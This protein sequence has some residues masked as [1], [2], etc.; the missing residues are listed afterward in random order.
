MSLS[1]S[2]DANRW[3]LSRR[4][5]IRL[6]AGVVPAVWL[7]SQ[8]SVF[9]QEPE[10]QNQGDAMLS[11]LFQ[12]EES[13]AP[14]LMARPGMLA[15][16]DQRLKKRIGGVDAAYVGLKESWSERADALASRYAAPEPDFSFAARSD[17]LDLVIGL[18]LLEGQG[19]ATD[20]QRQAM[21]RTSLAL[22]DGLGRAGKKTIDLHVGQAS[23]MMPLAVAYDWLY[24]HLSADQRRSMMTAMIDYSVRP[25]L[26]A[27]Y[28]YDPRAWWVNGMNNW[29]TICIGGAIAAVLAARPD[30]VP[31]TFGVQTTANGP[32]VVR[33][34]AEHADDLIRRGLSNLRRPLIQLQSNNG[35]WGEGSGYQ[36]DA[37]LP[38]FSL[39]ASVEG[40]LKPGARPAGIVKAFLDD[41]RQGATLHL[42]SS[43]HLASP[44]GVDFPYSDG[45]WPLTK[46]PINLLVAGYGRDAA[47]PLWKA[48]AQQA[49]RLGGDRDRGLYLLYASQFDE[50]E[51]SP[52]ASE[53]PPT[54]IYFFSGK[55]ELP[56]E[57]KPVPNPH[58]VIW[59]QNWHDPL[60]AAVMFKGGDNRMD[61]H[62]HLDAG[63][64]IYDWAGVRWAIDLGRA[65]GYVPYLKDG[66][67]AYRPNATVFFQPYPKR[68]CGHNTLVINPADNDYTRR[69]VPPPWDWLWQINP[70][71][72]LFDADAWSPVTGLQTDAAADTWRGSVELTPVYRRHGA[73]E[74]CRRS[75]EF[76]CTSGR[77]TITDTLNFTGPN[78]DCWWFMHL[79]ANVVVDATNPRDVLL[80]AKLADGKTARLRVKVAGEHSFVFSPIDQNLPPGQP[81]DAWLWG[82]GQAIKQKRELKK[83]SIHCPT[84]TASLW[85]AVTIVPDVIS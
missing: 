78:N 47:S 30:D 48:V 55:A 66:N 41:A 80:S 2:D 15:R 83:L 42:Q 13:Q 77:L 16:A 79:P 74:G 54:G 9:G 8:A 33:P 4:Q 69:R 73:R 6:A 71:Q 25:T 62:S 1:H 38:W 12:F 70:D 31:G 7:Q 57:N 60:A 10:S 56:P 40:A 28:G 20:A 19:D 64:F 32:A 46:E 11:E 58:V 29:T 67:K 61:Y 14:R 22:V 76:D 68:A 53:A 84:S 36:H 27:L 5:I 50:A 3:T 23:N 44:V 51:L 17:L 24:P 37:M 45:T 35:L 18:R 59:R 34:F 52:S 21:V 39:L 72:A 82:Y 43:L 75:F 81:A 65:D 85:L 49:S 63:S 26:E